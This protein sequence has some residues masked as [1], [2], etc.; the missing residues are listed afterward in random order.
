MK[1]SALLM[2]V[3]LFLVGLIPVLPALAQDN[4]QLAVLEVELW[5]EYDR[6]EMLVI[7]RGEL[8]D[9]VTFPTAVSLRIPSR[10]ASPFVVAAQPLPDASV[11]EVN[12]ENVESGEWRTITFETSGPRFQ[13]EYY[14]SL[15]RTDDAR[16][17][18]YTWPGDYAVNQMVVKFQQPPHSDNVTITPELPD[19]QVQ[20]G[21]GLLYHIGVFGPL[22]AGETFSVDVSYTRSD[23]TLTVD[24]LQAMQP[25]SAGAAQPPVS[26]P[27]A[28]PQAGGTSE[29][30]ILIVVLVAVVSFLLGAASMRLAI[31]WQM[32]RRRR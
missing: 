8:A 19:A 30:D 21:D 2:V 17:F 3:L 31:N 15:P 27:F 26:D 4:I 29:I 14:D 9:T 13:L 32:A 24:L 20:P 23:D 16:A 11:D 1:R 28:T 10:V 22:N 12:Y 18:A 7:Y 25:D 6:S 5:P